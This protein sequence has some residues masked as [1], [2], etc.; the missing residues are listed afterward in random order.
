LISNNSRQRNQRPHQAKGY[1]ATRGADPPNQD[2][3]GPSVCVPHT[4]R[5]EAREA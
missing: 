1:P 4:T 5:V 3:G 2:G